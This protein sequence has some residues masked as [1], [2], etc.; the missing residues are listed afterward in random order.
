MQDGKMLNL[1]KDYGQIT[2]T[3]VENARIARDAGM[4]NRTKQNAIM[5]YGCVK[6]SVRG[7]AKSKL[8]LAEDDTKRD[9]PTLFLTLINQTYTATFSHSQNIREMLSNIK[10]KAYQF[11]IIKMN[12]TIRTYVQM[13][14]GG[15][16]TV[17]MS[18]AE[19]MFYTFKAYKSIK[20]PSEWTQHV[21]HL[22]TKA[23]KQTSFKL[24][25]VMDSAQKK[26]S[27]LK[28][29][30]NWKPS[31]KSPDKHLVLLLAKFKTIVA[32]TVTA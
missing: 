9:G 24:E 7:N 23:G 27:D 13:I 8:A 4:D 31:N 3:T 15:P 16:N 19:M 26:F 22:E 11:N 6:N 2:T 28:T 30:N 5:L 12:S 18:E 20:A 32:Q 17:T 21:L 14:K 10:P 25:N 29:Q 1:F